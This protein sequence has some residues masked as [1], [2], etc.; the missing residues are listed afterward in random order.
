MCVIF[1]GGN[2]KPKVNCIGAAADSRIS[3]M[4]RTRSAV[5]FGAIGTGCI[6]RFFPPLYTLFRDDLRLVMD[7]CLYYCVFSKE[8]YISEKS[9][10]TS[11]FSLIIKMQLR[12]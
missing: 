11:L 10:S 1:K 5:V 4:K 2:S 6:M 9:D 8:S 7:V 12:L 3:L